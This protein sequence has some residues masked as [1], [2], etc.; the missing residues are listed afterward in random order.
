[1]EIVWK[2]KWKGFKFEA[3]TGLNSHFPCSTIVFESLS[4]WWI[5]LQIFA[6]SREKK[7]NSLI[8]VRSTAGLISSATLVL[9]TLMFGTVNAPDNL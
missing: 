9:V 8:L 4:G 1:M 3:V 5:I 7:A 6:M 2:R